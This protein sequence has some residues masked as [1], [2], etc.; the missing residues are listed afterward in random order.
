MKPLSDDG[1]AWRA[2]DGARRL[3]EWAWAGRTLFTMSGGASELAVGGQAA[4]AVRVEVRMPYRG[5]GA[6]TALCV[7]AQP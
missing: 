7:R 3:V 4:R 6:I 1:R 2:L 5:E